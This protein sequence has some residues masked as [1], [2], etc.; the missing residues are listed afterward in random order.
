MAIVKFAVVTGRE[1]GG[2]LDYITADEKTLAEL[3][4]GINCQVETAG[5]EMLVIQKAYGKTEGRRLVHIIQSFH[6]KDPVTLEQAHKIGL[7]FATQW[8][9]YQIVLAT[10]RDTDHIHNHFVMNSVRMSD[11]K[12]F[13]QSNKELEQVKIFSNTLCAENGLKI[14]PLKNPN[15]TSAISKE[16]YQVAIKGGSWKMQLLNVIDNA[17]KKSGSRED[18]IRNIKTQGYDVRWEDSYKYLTYFCPNNKKCRDIKLHDIRY[19]KERMEREFEIRRIKTAELAAGAREFASDTTELAADRTTTTAPIFADDR[20]AIFADTGDVVTNRELY[21]DD[22]QKT[23]SLGG[24]PNT[25]DTSEFKADD[26]GTFR[27]QADDLTGWEAEREIFFSGQAETSSNQADLDLAPAPDVATGIMGAV[28]KAGRALERS[29][30]DVPIITP[31]TKPN[32]DS[33]RYK[34]LAEKKNAQGQ[35]MGG[36]EEENT[37]NI[38]TM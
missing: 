12:K 25:A 1:V 13:H 6:P 18:F 14:C 20:G 11:G 17:M 4:T 7:E 33:K 22:K 10:H 28:I 19:L 29:A 38:H 34:K 23:T 2:S 32:T 3:K 15:N 26:L 31:L 8:Q 36:D 27:N 24:A 35:K 37:L 5:D 16:E 9:D 30:N 21:S